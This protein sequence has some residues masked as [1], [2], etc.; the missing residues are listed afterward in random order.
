MDASLLSSWTI[1]LSMVQARTG[2][3]GCRL[4]HLPIKGRLLL[5]KLDVAVLQAW[6]CCRPGS[7]AGLGG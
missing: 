1:I 7:V 2:G 3:N 6:Q 5:T 4:S